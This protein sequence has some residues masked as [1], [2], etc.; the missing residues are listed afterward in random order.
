MLDGFF[1]VFY[2]RGERRQV[3]GRLHVSEEQYD[4]TGFGHSLEREYL[5]TRRGTRTYLFMRPYV[6]QPNIV[7]D[8]VIAPKEYADAGSVLGR[9]AGSRVEGFRHVEIG[10][11]Q[12]WYYPADRVLVLWECFLDGRFR[13]VPLV[14]DTN[15]GQLWRGFE[16]WLVNRYTETERIVT[17]FADPIW[18]VKEYQAFLRTRGFR[19]GKPGTFS[20]LPE[21]PRTYDA[22]H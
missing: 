2:H 15:M 8:V 13:D 1:G 21:R 6:E 12:A 7:L 18:D 17:P 14:K 4:V 11:A 19:R 22:A 16:T 10:N 9:T 3:R 5:K 20:K